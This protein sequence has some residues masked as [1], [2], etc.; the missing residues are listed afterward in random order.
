MAR[1]FEV[2]RA[3]CHRLAPPSLAPPSLAPPS[4]TF[5]RDQDFEDQDFG[6]PNP[7]LLANSL[8]DFRVT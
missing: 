5:A 7:E 1:T 3:T 8:T 4:F 6:L 2:S